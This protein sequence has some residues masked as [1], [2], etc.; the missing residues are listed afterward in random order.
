[1]TPCG[2][3]GGSGRTSARAALQSIRF[4]CSPLSV[5]ARRRPL[6]IGCSFRVPDLPTYRGYW[7]RAPTVPLAVSSAVWFS[8]GGF[9]RSQ[10]SDRRALSASFAF[11]QSLAQRNLARRPQP[12]SS[13][14][15][16]WLPSALTGSE[17]HCLRVVQARYV[18]PAGFG[19]PLG[20]LLP[21]SPCRA[22]FIP[23]ALLG[24]AL[25]SFLLPEGIRAF[26]RGRTH[27]PFL[28]PVI[29]PPKRWAGP[30]VRGFWA[31][32]LPG[33]PG[34]RTRG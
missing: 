2:D 13:S 23:A 6:G 28:P 7:F 32:T 9:R 21:P 29:P 19:D 3:P 25:R 27:L 17:V 33:V 26:P 11:L 16:L 14:H 30:A 24:F 12:A 31:L 20:G 22:C 1:V 4:R 8:G 15:G 5:A 34:S 18:P 10:L